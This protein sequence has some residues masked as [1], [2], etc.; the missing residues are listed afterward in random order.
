MTSCTCDLVQIEDEDGTGW[1]LGIDP[2]CPVHG[3]VREPPAF[4]LDVPDRTIWLRVKDG[5][6]ALN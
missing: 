3:L 2:A 1:E 4:E 5:F 6:I